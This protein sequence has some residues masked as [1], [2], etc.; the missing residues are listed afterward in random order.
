[1]HPHVCASGS[2]GVRHPV[3][4]RASRNQLTESSTTGGAAPRAA[5]R[6]PRRHPPPSARWRPLRRPPSPRGSRSR[7]CAAP[8]GD[9]VSN[10][11]GRM[12]PACG[13]NR[14][15]L[16]ECGAN[17]TQIQMSWPNSVKRWPISAKCGEN[18]PNLGRVQTTG[19]TVERL[20]DTCLGTVKQLLRRLDSSGVTCCDAWRAT[21]LQR[22]GKVFLSG[23]L[24]TGMATPA[25]TPESSRCRGLPE[26]EV[27]R[28]VGQF[29]AGFGRA[30][31]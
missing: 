3:R 16:A 6:S 11:F 10:V 15:M 7:E 22:S 4:A 8:R 9:H 30:A 19:A 23:R 25:M 26:L 21:F 24:P 20:L 27:R 1:M 29:C 31:D 17:A 28:E 2:V 12:W 18:L 13:T 5:L 14:P